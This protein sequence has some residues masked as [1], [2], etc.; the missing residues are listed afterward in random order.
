MARNYR[1]FQFSELKIGSDYS[2]IVFIWGSTRKLICLAIVP[3]T[4]Y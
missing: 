3:R 2:D 1:W 4:F